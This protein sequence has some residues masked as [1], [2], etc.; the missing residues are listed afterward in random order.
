MSSLDHL[1]EK[2]LPSGL[3][4]TQ[5]WRVLVNAGWASAAIPITI[6]LGII[7]TGLLARMLGPEGIGALAI[8]SAVT[9]LFGSILSLT[10]SE[11][12]IVYT[13]QQLEKGNVKQANY[14]I[15]YFLL[16]DLTTSLMAFLGVALAAFFVPQVL[17][18]NREWSILQVLSG[19]MLIFQSTYWTCHAILRFCNRFSWTFYH[20]VIR[21]IIKTS[22]LG[23]FFWQKADLSAV[24]VLN[25]SLSL[26]DGVI[27]YLMAQSALK[28]RG[29]GQSK[30]SW[31]W[32]HV[33]GNIRHYQLL[34]HG[35][36]IVKSMNR[37][38]DTLIA[39]MIGSRVEVGYY[40]AGKQ[41]TDMIQIA[42]TSLVSSLFS[43]YSSLFFAG[44]YDQLRRLAM[45]FLLLFSGIAVAATL[46]LWFGAAWVV[47]IVLGPDFLPAVDVI[48]ILMISALLVLI[49][50]PLYSLP[51]AVGR[52]GPALWA[53]I[54]AICAQVVTMYLLVPTMGPLG[55]AWSNVI[56][57]IVWTIVML[58]CVIVVIRQERRDPQ[59]RLGSTK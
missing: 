17:G 47:K 3:R 32:W 21:S 29:L 5:T 54:A 8:F 57:F 38:V 23:V 6:A 10:S 43:E 51:A 42:G 14:L 26:F 49:M 48:R 24:V 4:R 9:A 37:Y 45:Q 11:P 28:G 59:S 19:L 44:K 2:L 35:R 33:S 13:A 22:L 56:Y 53:V 31:V 36:Q 41:V 15:R 20:S 50:S 7:Q 27:F 34:S 40:R 55:V 52:A 46:A 16:A 39:G 1:W 58:P 12:V 18:L 25:V 30:L